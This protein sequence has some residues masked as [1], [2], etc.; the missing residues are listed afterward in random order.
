MTSASNT[1]TPAFGEGPSGSADVSLEV[2]VRPA[3]EQDSLRAGIFS[4]GPL[5]IAGVINN[6]VN[7]VVTILL[8][9]L[10]TTHGYGRF[11]QLAG[12]FLII[13]TPGF[14]VAVAVVR[15]A[16]SWASSGSADR[17][18]AW[19]RRVQYQSTIAV[20]GFAVLVVIAGPW[21]SRTLRQPNA[22]GVSAILVAGAIFIVLSKD[23][24]LLQAHRAY[25]ALAVNL[26]VEGTVRTVVL[27][28]LVTGGLGASGA[29]VGILT[30][31]LV[32]ALHARIKADRVWAP[33]AQLPATPVFAARRHYEGVRA[34]CAS[35][36]TRWKAAIRSDQTFPGARN[37][38][39]IMIDVTA[40]IVGLAMIAILQNIDVII[41]GRDRPSASGAY[42]AVS[43]AA[44]VLVFGAIV[45]GGYLVPEAAIR[46]RN[47]GDALRQLGVVALLLSIPAAVL[48]VA[49]FAESHL[50]LSL[51]FSSR[52]LA[53]R[54][55]LGPMVVAMI[56]LSGTTVMTMYL[57]AIGR[58]WI[59]VALSVG[60]VAAAWAVSLA[61]GSPLAT[62]RADLVVQAG[63]F[64]VILLGFVLVHRRRLAVG[65]Q[66]G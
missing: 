3:E 53:A 40:A 52:Y 14:A 58:Y 31:E 4:A 9:R 66:L 59:S 11:N 23:R 35:V 62:A 36:A 47:G 12:L 6:G 46:W 13:S 5:A 19:G 25:G 39:A 42:A 21:L 49:G 1:G 32:A 38:R 48:L 51:V 60:A 44:K 50:L 41:L 8:A 55:A 29:A 26:L 64:F 30:G 27:L 54:A 37:H 7:V 15:K 22:V 61:H 43:V 20:G 24:G 28:G 33:D 56:F 10:L 65:Q 18:A 45:L 34:F 2:S 57:L 16:T 63:L 17:V